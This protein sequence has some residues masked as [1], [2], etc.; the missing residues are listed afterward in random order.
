MKISLEAMQ[1]TPAQPV[2]LGAAARAI[3]TPR[4]C[5][6]VGH[7]RRQIR[8]GPANGINLQ[9]P[10]FLCVPPHSFLSES[11]RKA[12]IKKLTPAQEAAI[13][14]LRSPET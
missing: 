14:K 2:N 10:F 4:R 8:A 11:I 3:S 5:E 9:P 12:V 1:L 13:T 6:Q 7:E